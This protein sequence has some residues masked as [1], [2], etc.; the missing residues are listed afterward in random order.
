M[1]PIIMAQVPSSHQ[2]RIV[3]VVYSKRGTKATRPTR[4]LG[5]LMAPAL[6]PPPPLLLLLLLLSLPS[7]SSGPPDLG[8]VGRGREEIVGSSPIVGTGSR[9]GSVKEGEEKVGS[10]REGRVM[11]AS[12]SSSSLLLPLPLPLLSSSSSSEPPLLPP[13]LPPP[14]ELEPYLQ[15]PSLRQVSPEKQYF[16]PPQQTLPLGMQPSSHSSWKL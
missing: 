8:P 9:D 1:F 13:L 5:T 16:P 10:V 14:P 3:Y 6:L 11:V 15:V 12:S 4:K 7:S 2:L